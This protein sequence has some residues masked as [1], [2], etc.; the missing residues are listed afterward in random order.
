LNYLWSGCEFIFSA[1]GNRLKDSRDQLVF[2]SDVRAAA[3][4]IPTSNTLQNVVEWSGWKPEGALSL[5]RLDNRYDTSSARAEFRTAATLGLEGLQRDALDAVSVSFGLLEL[6]D[7]NYM[8]RS[9]EEGKH[10]YFPDLTAD[11][12]VNRKKLMKDWTSYQPHFIT[13]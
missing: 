6:H 4:L 1:F 12:D 13:K 9:E 7:K 10:E 5:P 2:S 3:V 8:N 11:L